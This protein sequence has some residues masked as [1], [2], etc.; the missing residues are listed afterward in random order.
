MDSLDVCE[1][2]STHSLR[3]TC[4]ER[5]GA[6]VWSGSLIG[7]AG[8][9]PVVLGFAGSIPA[10]TFDGVDIVENNIAINT[11][12]ISSSL[13]LN[14]SL[15]SLTAMNG[16]I[17]NCGASGDPTDFVSVVIPGICICC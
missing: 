5:G 14:G 13:T 3:Y 1:V 17:L 8:N 16:T 11:T 12:C 15:L 10:S 2:V 9:I 7:G 6:L 4:I